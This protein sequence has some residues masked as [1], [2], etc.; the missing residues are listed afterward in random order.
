MINCIIVDDEPHC[1]Q[2]LEELIESF[3]KK[4]NLLARFTSA[5]DA[6]KFISKNKVDLVFSDIIMN[7]MTG[8]EFAGR[9]N[10]MAKIIFTTAHNDFAQ[11]SYDNEA[12]DYLV[13]PISMDRFKK[14]ISRLSPLK[15]SKGIFFIKDGAKKISIDIKQLIYLE[16]ADNYVKLFC[17]N[18]TSYILSATPLNDW[19]QQL[20]PFKFYRIHN[21]HIV[22]LPFIQ[23]FDYSHVEL[24]TG[25]KNMKLPI[26]DSYRDKF[27]NAVPMLGR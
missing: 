8:I 18:R 4:L 16:G 21:R 10:G 20:K 19:E 13:K 6:L 24:A 25:S 22:S 1:L 14:A 5:E 7:D 26:S 3:P 17:N 27:F 11:E 23:S 12:I 2:A 9:I 15:Q